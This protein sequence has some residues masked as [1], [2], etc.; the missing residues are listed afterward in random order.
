MGGQLPV[1]DSWPDWAVDKEDPGKNARKLACYVDRDRAKQLGL[2][3]A[4]CFSP[5]GEPEAGWA[6]AERL[7][8]ELRGRRI[9]YAHDP[10]NPARFDDEGKLF[11]QRVR[12]PYETIQGP[13]TCLDLALLFAGTAL[14]ADM[15]PLIGLRT[16]PLSDL[17]ALV[18]LDM[19]AALSGQ[20]EA[21]A[22]R[23]PDGF[24]ERSDEP[25]VW[26][27]TRT[28]ADDGRWLIIDVAEAARRRGRLA[29]TGFPAE[30]ASFDAAIW[31]ENSWSSSFDALTG[32]KWTLVDVNRV[33]ERLEPYVPPAGRAVPAIHGYLP[34]LPS[35]TD[36]GTRRDLLK[37]LHGMVGPGQPPAVIVLHGPSGRGKSMLARRLAAAADHNCGWF[38]NATDD[39]V[40][41]R[42][43][44]QAERREKAER[45]GDTDAVEDRASASAALSRLRDAERPWVVVL[46]NCDSPPDRR[47][48]RELIPR[49]QNPGQFVIITTTHEGWQEHAWR[50]GWHE[51]ELP[52]LDRE[53]LADLR[54]PPGLDAAVDG[55]PL[56]AQAL[57]AL[58]QR[59]SA[60]LPEESIL[61]GPDLVWDLVRA[62]PGRSS[63][64]TALA[65]IL[66][67]CPP[68]FTDVVTLLALTGSQSDPE[69]GQWLADMRFVTPDPAGGLA[70]QMHRLF[71]AAVRSQTWR[72]DPVASA[73]VIGRLLTS[74]PGRKILID[75]ADNSALA[76]LE[77]SE[78]GRKTV[79]LAAETLP[80]AYQAGLLWYGLGHI[81][82]RR[83][84]V[85]KSGEH[86]A[87]SVA[88]LDGG[89]FPF[90]VAEALIGQA[91]PVF[92]DKKSSNAALEAARAQVERA[93]QL[94]APL[95]ED[96]ARQMREQG[97]ALS[98][99]IAR[100][101]AGREGDLRKRVAQ[102]TEIRENLWLSYEERLR[103][104]RKSDAAQVS[105][106][107]PPESG[108]G[109]GA[110]R[111]Y[112]NLA[113]VNIE[114][115]KVHYALVGTPDSGKRVD[116][117]AAVARD[118]AEAADVY[119]RVRALRER[120]YKG[121]AHPHLAACVQ[122]Q[123]SVDY[124]SAVLLGLT[125]RLPTAFA[126]A[127][128]AM[129]QRRKVASGFASEDESAV[130]RDGD[131]RKSYE[132]M[133]K[134]TVAGVLAGNGE[135]GAGTST[136]MGVL[137]EALGEGLARAGWMS[138]DQED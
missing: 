5:W 138:S 35:F 130:L 107:T 91:R 57:A 62:S 9:P 72:E 10:W 82:E 101:L 102:L 74:E 117:L 125:Q 92:Q 13:A 71:A 68:E 53:D 54:L 83:G 3:P 77:G 127:A 98:W 73:D 7:Y 11:F 133:M 29:S 26:D 50:S 64:D 23:V 58:G 21:A 70:I 66:A 118:L 121:R 103:L 67:W 6:R 106:D 60:L 15:R 30:G 65:R 90:A 128:E 22:R 88:T 105:R 20:A 95:P 104:V 93:R 97:N 80:D 25:G 76:R 34:A 28:F 79:D 129:E 112:Y 122:G 113:G 33:R 116:W 18:V 75:A 44:A 39:K 110:E 78:D 47:G 31:Q 40:L 132:F 43:L 96:D 114:L 61:A 86:F 51:R 56:I 41:T 137:S 89:E 38:L 100:V 136:A 123:A 59:D 48:L 37:E 17:H 49:P 126:F 8:D 14:D 1:P 81:R 94:L 45:E 42:S 134:V 119:E 124:F 131:V 46:D 4:D 63:D 108:D 19:T 115:A 120:R 12:T 111:A 55:R 32:E 99:L 2:V 27:L 52:S 24:T 16:S 87:R 84:P 109:L 135:P 69:A 85:A 36:Y